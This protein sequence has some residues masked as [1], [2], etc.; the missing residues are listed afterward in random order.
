M[1]DP[2]TLRQT[3]SARRVGKDHAIVIGASMG[4]LLAARVLSD[5]FRHVTLI[6]RDNLPEHAENRKGVP[7][8]QH[9]HALLVRGEQIFSRLFP[10]LA[11]DL[12]QAGAVQVDL[13]G[14]FLWFQE[15][16]YKVRFH[17]GLT[18]TCMSRPLL[19]CYVRR[20]ILAI[21]NLT[22]LQQ[23]DVQSLVTNADRTRVMGV[24]VR[25]RAEGSD[26]ESLEADIVVDATGRG[27]KSPK[28]LETLGY[29]KPKESVVKVDVGY[30]T[31]M[32][33]QEAG[34]LPNAKAIFTLPAPPQGKRGGGLFPIEGG[35]WMVTLAGWLGDH[36][37]ADEQG[38]LEYA[39]SLPNQDIYNIISRAKPLNDFVTHKLPS[40]LRR[41]YE[42][43]TSFPDGYLVMGDAICSFN[44]VYGQGMSVSAMEAEALDN[45][46]K[47]AGGRNSLRGLAQSFFKGAARAIENPWTLAAG[48]DFRFPGVEG[49][50]PM[51]TDLINR[52]VSQVHKTT[53]YDRETTRAF[54][55]VMTLTHSP[56]ILF[57]PAIVLRIV[58]DRFAPRRPNKRA[59]DYA[60]R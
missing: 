25:R 12:I 60:D 29:P 43:M 47:R 27:S 21:K 2:E 22:C 35:R 49:P 33:R 17:S 13:P 30:T 41:H 10:G 36:A 19:E 59:M 26:E 8:G 4:G 9:L 54:F 28:W 37:P 44:P 51:G 39:K 6:E 57:S 38:F 32:Y 20:R 5:H 7:Q 14:D 45:C 1:N 24:K 34:L 53:M 3:N 18:M 55:Q 42:R 50:K 46:L 23:H 48:E 31:R 15:G 58:R 56:K 11:A 40:N 16:V 52:Y